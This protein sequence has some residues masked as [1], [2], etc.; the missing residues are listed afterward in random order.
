MEQIEE[1]LLS[2]V[3]KQK[4]EEVMALTRPMDYHSQARTLTLRQEKTSKSF[5]EGTIPVICAGS[6]NIGV[7]K[8][9]ALTAELMDNKVQ[10]NYDVGVTGLHRLLVAREQLRDAALLGML[11]SCLPGVWVVNIDKWFRVRLSCCDN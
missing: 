3:D 6:S 4:A 8:E 10:R 5:A 11:N 1:I 9:A 2:L 7:A